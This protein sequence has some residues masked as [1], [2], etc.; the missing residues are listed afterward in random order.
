MEE[1]RIINDKLMNE[2]AADGY[3][4]SY[5]KVLSNFVG[6][7]VITNKDGLTSIFDE[8]VFQNHLNFNVEDYYKNLKQIILDSFKEQKEIIEDKQKE[9][10]EDENK[11]INEIFILMK[12]GN[13]TLTEINTLTD[14]DRFFLSRWF[15][16]CHDNEQSQAKSFLKR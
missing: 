10:I 14:K 11:R 8:D 15:K 5:K 16:E 9:I 12:L 1:I 7:I 4:I 6:N 3:V 2:L 13:M